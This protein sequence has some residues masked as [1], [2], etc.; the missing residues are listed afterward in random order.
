V[1]FKEPNDARFIAGYLCN[2][3]NIVYFK[4]YFKEPNDAM[5]LQLNIYDIYTIL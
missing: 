5:D 1:Y 3:I 2:F 4:V